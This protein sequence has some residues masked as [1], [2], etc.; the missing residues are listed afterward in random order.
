MDVFILALIN[1]IVVGLGVT[2][3]SY[4]ANKAL[5]QQIESA[6]NKLKREM[7]NGKSDQAA[8]SQLTLDNEHS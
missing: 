3:G 2:I 6:L 8:T 5:I 4:I 1:G 7:K